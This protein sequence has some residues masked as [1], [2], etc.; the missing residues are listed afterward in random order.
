MVLLLGGTAM[1]F[2]GSLSPWFFAAQAALLTVAVFVVR[3]PGVNLLLEQQSQDTGSAAAPIQFC[4]TIMGATGIQIVSANSHN[5]IRN[6]GVLLI[7]IG[8]ICAALWMI[9]QRRP[10]VADKLFQPS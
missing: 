8:T 6:Y 3:V 7:V 4:G 9:V 5:L 2:V 1:F 10:F